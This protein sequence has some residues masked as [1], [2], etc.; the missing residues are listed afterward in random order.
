[1]THTGPVYAR[2]SCAVASGVT[3]N[4]LEGTSVRFD[5]PLACHERLAEVDDLVTM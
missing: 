4:D 3:Q 5:T 2:G 1:M